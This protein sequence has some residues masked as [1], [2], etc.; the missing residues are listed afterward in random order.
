M[1]ILLVRLRLIGDV[2]FTTPVIRALRLRYPDAQLVYLVEEDAAPVVAQNPHLNS[3]I[4]GEKIIDARA[5]SG[6]GDP[7]QLAKDQD[8]LKGATGALAEK[9]GAG[10]PTKP[11]G[12][13]E[14]KAGDKPGKPGDED[15]GANKEDTDKP[16]SDERENP[17]KSDPMKGDGSEGKPSKGGPPMDGGKPSK[18]APK[19]GA[20]A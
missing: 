20:E 4:R 1:N 11:G 3:I 17:N 2:V 6:K 16:K 7:K 19:D 8:K 5:N 14:P 15:Q 9:M 13:G 10:K 18:G 12:E